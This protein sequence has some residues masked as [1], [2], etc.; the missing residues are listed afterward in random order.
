MQ[1]FAILII[2]ITS[3]FARPSEDHVKTG[4]IW[5]TKGG[6]YP[7]LPA[8]PKFFVHFLIRSFVINCLAKK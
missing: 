3:V 7:Q 8:Q 1:A 6:T 4:K 5:L 2:F